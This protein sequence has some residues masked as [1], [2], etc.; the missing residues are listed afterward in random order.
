MRLIIVGIFFWIIKPRYLTNIIFDE[1]NFFNVF[2][3]EI[4][5]TI[6]VLIGVAIIF[7]VYPFAYSIISGIY[8]LFILAI[9]ILDFFLYN[10]PSYKAFQEYSIFFTSIMLIFITK[11]IQD[12]LRHFGSTDLARKWS[13]FAI[14][15]SVGFTIPYYIFLTLKNYGFITFHI[16]SISGKMFLHLAPVI[17]VLLFCFGYYMYYLVKSINYLTAIQKKYLASKSTKKSS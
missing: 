8:I 4:I 13:S 7:R 3:F 15:I 9:N 6:L 1:T 14:I 17:V 11:L 16:P 5:G 12:G 10:N 2:G